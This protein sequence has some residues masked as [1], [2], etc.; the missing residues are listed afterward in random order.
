[1]LVVIALIVGM[2]AS[3]GLVRPSAV[4]AQATVPTTATLTPATIPVFLSISI[5]PASPQ[6]VQGD[7]LLRRLG[8]GD[9]F[10]GLVGDRDD[11]LDSSLGS[12]LDNG[13]PD[14]ELAIVVTDPNAFLAAMAGSS[15]DESPNSG[16]ALIVYAPGKADAIVA[17]EEATLSQDDDDESP[18]RTTYNGVTIISVPGNEAFAAIGNAVIMSDSPQALYGLIDVYAGDAE[19]LADADDFTTVRSDLPTDAVAYGYIDGASLRAPL[20]QYAF[21]NPA[22][23]QIGILFSLMP[24]LNNTFGLAISSA[25]DQFQFDLR[26]APASAGSTPVAQ[27]APE[28]TLDQQVGAD[29]LVFFNGVDLGKTA[30]MNLLSLAL[31]QGVASLISDQTGLITGEPAQ[32]Y[33][34]A[35]RVL[36]FNLRDVFDQMVGEYAL[37]ASAISLDV[38]GIDAVLVSGVDNVEMVK[39]AAAKTA[40]LLNAA[41]FD[42]GTGTAPAP[43][44]QQVAN[45]TI[46]VLDLAVDD[47]GTV[48]HVEL[49]VVGDTFLLG[50]RSGVRDY[51]AGPTD[52]LASNPRYQ[53]AMSVLPADRDW[54]LYVDLG[55][56]IPLAQGADP[57]IAEQTAPFALDNAESLSAAGFTRDGVTGMTLV[58]S[59]PVDGQSSSATPVASGQ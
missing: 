3:L 6:L 58:I 31:A 52:T 18:Q 40:V 45:G 34:A 19:A 59:I 28:L 37:A 57:S 10:T 12:V 48:A 32:F 26:A 17:D 43:E 13:I 29:T 39:D 38:G 41:S 36:T 30:G 4:R 9:L 14:G 46:Q 33:E 24:Y 51:L 16:M 49:G 8:L 53:H 5:D 21:S 54:Q 35:Q 23:S 2:S 1:M 11:G 55:T 56:L 42:N 50:Y 27:T 20:Q 44:V 7:A 47:I 25:D 15:D 22:P